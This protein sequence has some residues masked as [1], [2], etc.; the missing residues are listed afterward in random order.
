MREHGFHFAFSASI[1]QHEP[2]SKFLWKSIVIF[3][4]VSGRI[5]KKPKGMEAEK[6]L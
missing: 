4:F 1:L 5:G 6:T 3:D 2:A